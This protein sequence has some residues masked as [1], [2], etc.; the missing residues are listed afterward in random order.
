MAL[1]GIAKGREDRKERHEV[2]NGV[3]PER[4]A[5]HTGG[6]A[7]ADVPGAV[8]GGVAAQPLDQ[9][10]PPNEAERDGGHRRREH[11][12]EHRHDDV[13]HQHDRHGRRPG[14]H[15]RALPVRAPTPATSSPSLKRVASMSAPIGT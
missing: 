6:G 1:A 15:Q 3:L 13:C 12:S 9:A 8:A 11:R 2:K 4:P 7:D 5:D 14:D 10:G